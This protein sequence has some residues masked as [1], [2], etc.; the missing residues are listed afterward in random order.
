MWSPAL[1]TGFRSDIGDGRDKSKNRIMIPMPVH[2]ISILIVEDAQE[3]R[4]AIEALLRRDGYWVCPA[5]NEDDAVARIHANPP[6]LILISLGG[7]TEHLLSTARRIRDRSG[8]TTSTPIVIFSLTNFPEGVEEQIGGNVFITA[9]D[10][11]DQLR[12]LLIRVL[13][14]S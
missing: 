8:L 13:R 11:F 10:N 2:A 6:D 14:K 4:D 7:T 5:R 3:M 12:T 9:P 1:K